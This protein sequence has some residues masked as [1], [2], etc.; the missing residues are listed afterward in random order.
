MAFNAIADSASAVTRIQHV[1]TADVVSGP[2]DVDETLGCAMSVGKA[3]FE[4]EDLTSVAG[5]LMKPV[6][7]KNVGPVAAVRW[8]GHQVKNAAAA[9]NPKKRRSSEP[10]AENVNEKTL[11]KSPR[12]TFQ[13]RD[14]TLNIPHGALWA[15][16]GPV[17]SGKSSLLQGLVGGMFE[18][19][20]R[21][22]MSEASSQRC[23][24]QQDRSYSGARWHTARR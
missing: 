13:I 5:V 20:S 19:S 7:K 6:A 8:A 12:A 11:T 2:V 21:R 23:P 17:G 1:L 4:W 9:L 3:T 10:N 14:V 22:V 16:V 15:I 18:T 24:V